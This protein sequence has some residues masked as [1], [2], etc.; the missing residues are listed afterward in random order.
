MTVFSGANPPCKL[1]Y[2]L[3]CAWARLDHYKL[4]GTYVETLIE[5]EELSPE[6]YLVRTEDGFWVSDA[7]QGTLCHIK[8]SNSPSEVS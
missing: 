6:S 8:R 4:N 1:R 7:I 2:V 3:P 5:L